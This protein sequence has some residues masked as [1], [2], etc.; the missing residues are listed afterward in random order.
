MDRLSEIKNERM[1]TGRVRITASKRT[2]IDDKACRGWYTA[3]TI[4]V[5]ARSVEAGILIASHD[6]IA[7][8]LNYIGVEGPQAT[9]LEQTRSLFARTLVEKTKKNAAPDPGTKKGKAAGK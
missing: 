9:L 8:E 3:K 1:K 7:V 4:R 2:T 5:G 6:V